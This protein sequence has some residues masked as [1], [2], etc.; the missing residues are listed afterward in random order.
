LFLTGTENSNEENFMTSSI[1]PY[2]WNAAPATAADIDNVLGNHSDEIDKKLL[3]Y[4][5]IL[6]K[7]FIMIIDNMLTA[8]GC[9]PFT[10]SRKILVSIT[11]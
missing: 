2:I 9:S 7:G 1:L 11:N 6:F 4:G 10:G 3:E 8:H 5:A